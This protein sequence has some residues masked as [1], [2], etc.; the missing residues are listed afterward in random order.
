MTDKRGQII[1]DIAPTSPKTQQY[2]PLHKNDI[3]STIT[4]TTNMN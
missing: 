3:F 2:F 4:P 1:N